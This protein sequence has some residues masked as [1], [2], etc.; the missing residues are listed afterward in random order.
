MTVGQVLLLNL[1]TDGPPAVALAADAASDD[2][3]ALR[4]GSP[5]LGQRLVRALLGVAALIGLVALI[6]FLVVREA[7]P[8]AAQT[9][10]FATVAL[11]ELAFVFSCRSELVPSW[12]LRRNPWLWAAVA[13]SFG[14]VL[15]LVYVPQLHEPF[16]T[17][18]LT[19]G[20][21]GLVVVLALVPAA[22]AEGLKW[23]D[24][25]HRSRR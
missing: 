3:V 13:T 18:A 24:R 1:V 23:W 6:A 2:R 12:R 21:L 7:R 17:L 25:A 14:I 22:A 11:A 8:E 10:A 20:E 9:A 19:P 15:A 4:R 16:D 5:L